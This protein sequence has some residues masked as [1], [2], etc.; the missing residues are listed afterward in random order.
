MPLMFALRVV[1]EALKK[2]TASK[3]YSFGCVALDQFKSRLKDYPRYCQS[4]VQLPKIQQLQPRLLEVCI[5]SVM[6]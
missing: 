5:I 3:L 4:L 2:D 1:L 6:F